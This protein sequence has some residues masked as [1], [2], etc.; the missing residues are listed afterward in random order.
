MNYN[1]YNYLLIVISLLFFTSCSDEQINAYKVDKDKLDLLLLEANYDLDSIYAKTNIPKKLITQLYI[2]KAQFLKKGQEEFDNIIEDLTDDGFKELD[3]EDYEEFDETTYAIN[4]NYNIELELER[5]YIKE[6]ALNDSIQSQVYSNSIHFFEKN[7]EFI[8]DEEFDFWSDFGHMWDALLVK[9]YISNQKG[10]DDNWNVI[11][12]KAYNTKLLDED[13]SLLVNNYSIFKNDI[14][15]LL[16]M[17]TN[18]TVNNYSHI[19]FALNSVNDQKS[20]LSFID[21]KLNNELLDQFS[22][23]IFGIIIAFLIALTIGRLAKAAKKD[24][25][26]NARLRGNAISSVLGHFG[27]KDDSFIG[28]FANAW[29]TAS[30]SQQKAE[31]DYRFNATINTLKF[32]LL[33]IFFICSLIYFNKENIKIEENIVLQLEESYTEY[34]KNNDFEIRTELDNHTTEFYKTL[35]K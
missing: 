16:K 8:I 6:L 23:W 15:S 11:F 5:L 9:T 2:D 10:F 1:H 21:Q 4:P 29:N 32:V 13:L 25:D 17:T 30:A 31:S 34:L 7:T 14:H 22:E 3:R 24:I 33:G 19:D 12:N 20:I 35:A 28:I 26:E 27:K 18:N